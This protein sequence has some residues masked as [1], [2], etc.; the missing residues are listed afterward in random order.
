MLLQAALTTMLFS[1]RFDEHC[2]KRRLGDLLRHRQA[3]W[4]RNSYPNITSLAAYSWKEIWQTD[5]K[6]QE[7]QPY[8][9]DEG[10]SKPLEKPIA[11]SVA[12]HNGTNAPPLLAPCS[13][14]AN[15]AEPPT[16]EP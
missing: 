12:Y 15:I 1:P 16:A 8:T 13:R 11:E 5:R 3:E 9:Y 4:P 2:I 7:P 14:A 10:L 6:N